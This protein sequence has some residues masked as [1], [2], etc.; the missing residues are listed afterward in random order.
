[1]IAGA[2][3]GL[4]QCAPRCNWLGKRNGDVTQNCKELLG[5]VTHNGKELL[6]DVTQRIPFNNAQCK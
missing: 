1:M 4:M 5:D 3:C 6:G 2:T